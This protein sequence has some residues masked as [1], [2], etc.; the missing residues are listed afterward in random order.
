M[1]KRK[2]V[3]PMMT[4]RGGSL[5]AELIV[6]KE[7]FLYGEKG[8]SYTFTVKATN[9]NGDSENSTASASITTDQISFEHSG[10][11]FTQ[12]HKKLNETKTHFNKDLNQPNLPPQKPKTLSTFNNS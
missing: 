3:G 4:M 2:I 5:W 9:A 6:P 7:T 12:P 8:T 10:G 1:G 11:L